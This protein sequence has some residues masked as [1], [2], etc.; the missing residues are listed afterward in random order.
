MKIKYEK[1]F[2]PIFYSDQKVPI[3]KLKNRSN[4]DPYFLLG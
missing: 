2:Y 4:T 3:M 1:L